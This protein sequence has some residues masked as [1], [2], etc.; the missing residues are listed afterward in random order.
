VFINYSDRNLSEVRSKFC[1]DAFGPKRRENTGQLSIQ[2][3][4]FLRREDAE[5][6]K[7]FMIDKFGSGEVGEPTIID[8]VL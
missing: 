3:A 7:E 5:V 4:S 8:R 6:F 1:K 2:V